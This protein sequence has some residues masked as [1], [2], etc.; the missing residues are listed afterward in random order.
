M[1]YYDAKGILIARAHRYL[2]PNGTLGGSGLP[3]PKWLRLS[4]RIIA[5]RDKPY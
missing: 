4:D 3:D 1:H 5:F 2:R